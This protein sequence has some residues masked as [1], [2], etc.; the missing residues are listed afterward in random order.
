M[1]LYLSGQIHFRIKNILSNSCCCD[2]ATMTA[3]RDIFLF[4]NVWKTFILLS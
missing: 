2:R 3:I 1:R 4:E